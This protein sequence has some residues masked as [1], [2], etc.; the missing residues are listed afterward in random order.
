MGSG[1]DYPWGDVILLFPKAYFDKTILGR[2]TNQ[3]HSAVYIEFTENVGPVVFNGL[4][5]D[6]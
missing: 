1:R 3:F 4:L 2:V 5:T 6:K